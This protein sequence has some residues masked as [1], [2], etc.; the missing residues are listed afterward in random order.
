MQ[1]RILNLCGIFLIASLAACS[2]IANPDYRYGE[3]DGG[4]T[5]GN[6]NGKDSGADASN[7]AAVDAGEGG[8]QK[9]FTVGGK[10]S[11]LT[12]SGLVLQNNGA[13]N[14]TVTEN[15]SFTFDTALK[16][17]ALYSVTVYQQPSSPAQ[18]CSISEGSGAVEGENVTSVTVT[19]YPPSCYGVGLDCDDNGEPISCC[20][21][22]LVPGG[23][24]P[25][26]RCGPADAG[27]SDAYD[28]N[29]DELP[30]HS[31][32]VA[33]FFLDTF[34]VTVGRFRRFVDQYNGAPPPQ[35]AGA[36]SL[37]PGSGWQSD[38]NSNLPT[39]QASLISNL[40]C[41]ATWQ[42]WTDEAGANE[43]YPINCV[44][45][46]EAFAFCIWDGGR[47]PTEA[48]WEYAAAGGT[49]N[50]LYPW[51]SEAPNIAP[52]RA[53]YS[54]TAKSPFIDVGSYPD[55][56]GRW[57]QHDLAGSMYEWVLDWFDDSW[58]SGGGNTCNNCANIIS[59]SDR[60]CRGGRWGQIATVM[61]SAYRNSPSPTHR[62]TNLGFRCGRNP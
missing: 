58:Y 26:G 25:M 33:D 32:T 44:N 22:R 2:L 8:V 35:D 1:H 13:D 55:G 6:R 57:G 38:W 60:V 21:S 11:G 59:G 56:A 37:I 29:T 40:K 52:L 61:R 7:D 15:G 12:G 4:G 41:D 49:Y 62:G 24:F 45:W 20:D 23:T 16:D 53:N 31:A 9:T 50:R 48:E 3:T 5:N 19:C 47:L 36:N 27:C 42:T 43:Q 39:N 54:G 28:G 14:K 51:G 17:G 10:V 18:S 46:Y 34:E 30:E